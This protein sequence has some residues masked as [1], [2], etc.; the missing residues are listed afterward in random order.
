MRSLA[1]TAVRSIRRR[2]PVTEVIPINLGEMST[3][4]LRQFLNDAAQP[5]LLWPVGSTEPHGPHLPLATDTILADENGRRA[6]RRLRAMGI[7]AVVAPAL[8]YGVTDYA[9]GFRG[10]VSIPGPVL[11]NF[12]VAGIEAYL[13]DGFSHVCL[14]NHHLETG[15]IDA[16]TA[17][18]DTIAERHGPERISFPRVISR[19]WGRDLGAEFRSGA[20]H[21]GAYEGSLILAATPQLYRHDRAQTLEEVPISLSTAMRAGQKTFLEAGVDQ[22]YT[23]RPA[24][25]TTDE[26]ERLYAVLTDMVA[27]EVKEHL[28]IS[29]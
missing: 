11:V 9:A 12:L 3:T 18:H 10:A 21:A 8:P 26:G 2:F 6:A 17:V 13:A 15:Q 24:D 27:T 20:C 4:D 1:M 28:E 14:I 19:R 23:G 25:A 16:L 7:E 5:V 22:A 29:S